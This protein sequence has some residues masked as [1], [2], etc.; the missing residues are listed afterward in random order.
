MDGEA[1]WGIGSPA[2]GVCLCAPRRTILRLAAR[3]LTANQAIVLGSASAWAGQRLHRSTGILPRSQLQWPAPRSI[4]WRGSAGKFIVVVAAGIAALGLAV[5]YGLQQGAEKAKY[6]E[7]RA[8]PCLR[9]DY[10]MLWDAQELKMDGGTFDAYTGMYT[11]LA[12]FK[13][14]DQQCPSLVTADPL[15][16]PDEYEDALVKVV[17]NVCNVQVARSASCPNSGSSAVVTLTTAQP[18]VIARQLV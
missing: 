4:S 18:S 14:W 3:V 2:A 1:A 10:G 11:S 8:P 7:L 16:E 6:S 15:L 5:F 9:Q 17:K 12:N 13:T